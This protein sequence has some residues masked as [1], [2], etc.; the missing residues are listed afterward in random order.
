MLL[1]DMALDFMLVYNNLSFMSR[2]GIKMDSKEILT[3]LEIIKLAIEINDT[4]ATILQA[5]HLK[6]VGNRKIDEIIELL[7]SKNYRQAL[8][9][10]KAF[11]SNDD[12]ESLGGTFSQNGDDG[13][14]VLGIEDMLRMSP[15]AKETIKAYK[16][17][18]YT[19]DD[20][21]AFSK[22][23]ET[24]VSDAYNTK[25]SIQ[26]E[27]SY[28]DT[29][30]QIQDK[31][32][33]KEAT[34]DE[35]SADLNNSKDNDGDTPLDEMKV[36]SNDGESGEKRA[37]VISK[38]KMLRS[39]FSKQKADDS[40]KAV[41]PSLTKSVLSKAKNLT[42]KIKKV[43]ASNAV[44]KGANIKPENKNP[45][46]AETEKTTPKPEIEINDIYPPIPHIEQ[47]YRQ[48][49]VL[50]TPNKESEVWVEEVIKF[51]KHISANSYT[52]KDVQNFLNEYN[53]HL[54]QGNSAKAAQVLLLASAT[55]SK[56][57]QFI[58]ARELFNGRVLR[59][60]LK[61]SYTIMKSLAN[62]LY[63]DAICDLAQFYEYGIGVPK[64]KKIAVKLYE[65]AF[66]LG[67]DRA[68]KHI[69][70]IKESSG[71]LFSSILKF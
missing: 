42:E 3:R 62:T 23:I 29:F 10:I 2:E 26:D 37:E 43:D 18:K 69:N 13:E 39:K 15:L 51:L 49:F 32:P 66:E 55:D 50:Y 24:P 65:K 48:S 20:L 46:K 17:S 5:T 1:Y 40:K 70:R 30:Q 47:K 31:Q 27:Y 59:R 45:K 25:P 52:D 19:K 71:G 7:Y 58:L 41:K 12:I 54:K 68:T 21:E 56:Y 64:D 38:Y 9:L 57:A 22:N 28:A 36:D 44:D 53:F 11:F 4:D 63:P 67:V 16:K 14:T 6:R 8:Y 61:K 33:E 60:D 34:E 35:K